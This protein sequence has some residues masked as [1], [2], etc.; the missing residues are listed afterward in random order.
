MGYFFPSCTVSNV[1]VSII[2]PTAV[3]MYIAKVNR[4]I[5][6]D[7]F[8]FSLARETIGTNF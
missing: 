8:P 4:P 7:F 2:I 3:I 1:N 6:Y 5:V